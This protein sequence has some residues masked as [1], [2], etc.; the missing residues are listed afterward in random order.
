MQLENQQFY[1]AV[2]ASTK[3]ANIYSPAFA[4]EAMS[5][6]SEVTALDKES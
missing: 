2:F 4:K 1:M 5:Q 3:R 6:C